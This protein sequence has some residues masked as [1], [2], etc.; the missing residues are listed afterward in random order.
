MDLSP[1]SVQASLMDNVADVPRTLCNKTGPRCACF[2]R[3]GKGPWKPYEAMEGKSFP[4][5]RAWR[6]THGCDQVLMCRNG[7]M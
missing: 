5:R 3:A 4:G 2:E 7:V 6:D 1:D